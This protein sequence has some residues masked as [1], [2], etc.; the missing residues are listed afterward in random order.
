MLAKAVT[1]QSVV[2]ILDAT[3][4][5]GRWIESQPGLSSFKRIT[6]SPALE[7]DDMVNDA[8]D[9]VSSDVVSDDVGGGRSTGHR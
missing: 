5:R 2:I 7:V 6:T 4:T 3:P 8:L 1:H 9:D